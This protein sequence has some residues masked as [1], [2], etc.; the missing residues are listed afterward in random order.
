MSSN[1]MLGMS[2]SDESDLTTSIRP[3]STGLRTDELARHSELGQH[4]QQVP[5]GTS[6]AECTS[7]VSQGIR[8]GRS[9]AG[10]ADTAVVTVRRRGTVVRGCRPPQGRNDGRP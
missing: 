10:R 8:D 7:H 3:V 1:A 4:L 9:D 6:A 5:R 2:L